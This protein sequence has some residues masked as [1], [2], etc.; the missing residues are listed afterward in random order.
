MQKLSDSMRPKTKRC[1]ANNAIQLYK[2][3]FNEAPGPRVKS[4]KF[5]GLSANYT[6]IPELVR[7]AECFASPHSK[8][9]VVNFGAALAMH[10]GY[11]A[12]HEYLKEATKEFKVDR[13]ALL[14]QECEGPVLAAN[15]VPYSMLLDRVVNELLPPFLRF[16][17]QRG[18]AEHYGHHMIV[19]RALV[20]VLNVVEPNA[21]SALHKVRI[22]HKQPTSD[23][24]AD[25]QTNI[26]LVPV[27][28]NEPCV[29]F[30]NSDKVSGKGHLGPANWELGPA[31][32]R[33]VRQSFLVYP[34]T[35]LFTRN[36]HSDEPMSYWAYMHLISKTFTFGTRVVSA[37]V[38]RHS[39]INEWYKK[40]KSP[41]IAQKKWLA[42]RMRHDYHTQESCYRKIR[43]ETPFE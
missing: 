14:T 20:G 42:T 4:P 41:S 11:K 2:L 13:D 5:I 24:I 7:G 8:Y 28:A 31:A 19:M 22:V 34:R 27:P 16:V 38:L 30:V 43:E 36:I 39:L 29:L 40:Y 25:G 12:A 15:Y 26:M 9:N 10:M 18:F 3:L 21:R 35:W 17:A 6:R 1:Y 23:M 32:S 33:V 37:N